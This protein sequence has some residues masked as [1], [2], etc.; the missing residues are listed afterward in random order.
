MT[1]DEE[2]IQVEQV[3]GRLIASHPSVP[4][5]D[6]ELIVR[7]IHKRFSDA[8]VHDFVPLLVEK[9]ARQAISIR[10]AGTAAPSPRIRPRGTHP[11]TV[12]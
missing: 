3:I 1:G 10:P 7:G 8:R 11:V 4:P 6:I 12:I 9:A 2:L 5:G